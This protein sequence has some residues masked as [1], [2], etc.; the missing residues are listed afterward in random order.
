MRARISGR[1]IV[2]LPAAA[3]LVHQLRYWLSYG[4]QAS[5]QL[6]GTG[7][8]YLDSAV[9]WIVML[10]AAGVGIFAVRRRVGAHRS[11]VA[12][13]LGAAAFLVVL[14]TVQEAL[15]GI[16]STGHPGGFGGVYGHGG[17]WAIPVAVVVAFLLALVLRVADALARDPLAPPSTRGA[18]LLLAPV[19]VEPL[20]A[21]PL[22]TAAAGR[23][24][25]ST[26]R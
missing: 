23:A 2:F 24:P 5:N 9:P 17:W 18:R 8:A 13:W 10:T 3:V 4:S 26:S 14:F 1:G 11:F 21:R 20:R 7:H 25:P 16:F 19:A 12:R 22:A 15:E 6:S